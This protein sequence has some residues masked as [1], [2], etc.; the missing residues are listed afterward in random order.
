MSLQNSVFYRA[1]NDLA[2]EIWAGKFD[3]EIED[4]CFS[5]ALDFFSRGG[6]FGDNE[7]RKLQLNYM[8]GLYSHKDPEDILFRAEHIIPTENFVIEKILN[9]LCNIYS[10]PVTRK[11]N[12]EATKQKETIEKIQY[13]DFLNLLHKRARF[14]GNMLVFV[15]WDG[16]KI[17]LQDFTNAWYKWKNLGTIEKSTNL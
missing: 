6:S 16:E 3:T 2:N 12:N 15:G 11:W 14:N 4:T 10:Q 13:D 8:K 9:N 17:K 5:F 7:R 1:Y